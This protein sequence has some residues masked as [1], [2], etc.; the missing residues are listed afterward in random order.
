M[1]GVLPRLEVAQ[2]IVA[3]CVQVREGTNTCVLRCG[4]NSR[5]QLFKAVSFSV[6]LR[7]HYTRT[8]WDI[9]CMSQ[10]VFLNSTPTTTL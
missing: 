1:C 7:T 9:A 10:T 4:L 3:A 6:I 5:R 2:S 8:V